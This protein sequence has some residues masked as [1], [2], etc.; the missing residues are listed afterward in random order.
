MSEV[1]NTQLES[2]LGNILTAL[3]DYTEYTI[4]LADLDVNVLNTCVAL[5]KGV[6]VQGVTFGTSCGEVN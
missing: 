2:T 4:G 1:L 6:Y 5:L 3:G